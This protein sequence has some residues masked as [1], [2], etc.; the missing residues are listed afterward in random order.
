L[1][2]QKGNAPKDALWTHTECH[3]QN[4]ASFCELIE[5]VVVPYIKAT[6]EALG[7]DKNQKAQLKLDL[8]HSHKTPEV[9]ALCKANNICKW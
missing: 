6:I 3:W 5:K 8:H 2:H 7:L 1:C 9:L 4:S